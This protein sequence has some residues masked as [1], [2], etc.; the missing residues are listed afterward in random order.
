[1]A[2]GWARD[3]AVNDNFSAF[4][5]K[6]ASP[7]F[8]H[9][10]KEI[11]EA[12][13]FPWRAILQKWRDAGSISTEKKVPLDVGKGDARAL[14]IVPSRIFPLMTNYQLSAIPLFI[15]MAAMLERAGLI[16]EMFNVVYKWMGGVGG[17]M[18]WSG[19]VC[20]VAAHACCP[21]RAWLRRCGGC[22]ESMQ[23]YRLLAAGCH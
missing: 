1:M 23:G 22:V 18:G 4:V 21:L 11:M 2:G 13:F 6:L 15:F 10:N 8:K 20:C 7:H 19:I 17:G 12:H 5:V 9:D 3:G 14:N 16:E